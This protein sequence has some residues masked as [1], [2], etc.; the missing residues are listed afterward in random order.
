[1]ACI[2]QANRLAV[3]V[4]RGVQDRIVSL[5]MGMSAGSTLLDGH[6]TDGGWASPFSPRCIV[7]AVILN[8]RT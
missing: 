4:K 2:K 5:V 6:D 8:I 3:D 1:V 7:C